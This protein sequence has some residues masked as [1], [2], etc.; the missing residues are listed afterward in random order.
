MG[1]E[2][3]PI[4]IHQAVLRSSSEY[5]KRA[6][7]P[8]WSSQRPEPHSSSFCD[9]DPGVFRL[10]G[11]WV[12][13]RTLPI[14]HTMDP[15]DIFVELARAYVLGEKLI[16]AKFK[17]AIIDTFVAV[18]AGMSYNPSGRCVNILYEGTPE[19]SPA[20]KTVVDACG[21]YAHDS[22]SWIE[23][24]EK[25]PKEFLIDAVVELGRRKTSSDQNWLDDPRV[26]Y[27]KKPTVC[28]AHSFL[29]R[30]RNKLSRLTVVVEQFSLYLHSHT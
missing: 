10:Y 9:D 4:T 28:G 29:C 21:R 13:F 6:M 14:S 7:R 5:F 11:H 16:D 18:G 22:Q 26:Y 30:S 8:E 27:E 25:C 23:G 24:F 2:P 20:R 15:A 17:D 19:G 3:K 12:Y 1:A